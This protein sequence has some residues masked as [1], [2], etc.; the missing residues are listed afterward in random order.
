LHLSWLVSYDKM[1]VMKKRKKKRF[2]AV[3]MVKAMAREQIGTPPASRIVPDRKKKRK[4]GEK[5][6]P[7]LGKLLD[8]V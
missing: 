3:E 2:S 6:K 7:T 4:K 8:E 5:H 1:G